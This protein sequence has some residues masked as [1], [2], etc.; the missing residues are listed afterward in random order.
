MCEMALL[1]LCVQGSQAVVVKPIL[2][3]ATEGSKDLVPFSR[4]YT[5]QVHLDNLIDEYIQEQE[6]VCDLVC[7]LVI[8]LTFCCF[9]VVMFF[10]V[11]SESVAQLFPQ[12]PNTKN[13]NNAIFLHPCS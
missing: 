13:L 10:Y 9:G 7:S 3:K 2:A 1:H 4:I 5:S 12:I 6:Q 8:N 11:S